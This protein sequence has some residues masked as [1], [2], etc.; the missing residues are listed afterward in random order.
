ARTSSPSA[1]PSIR[2]STFGL[3][4]TC[5]IPPLPPPCGTSGK[6]GTG[7]SGT[8]AVMPI[9]SPAVMSS[10]YSIISL[11]GEEIPKKD[12]KLLARSLAK[13]LTVSLASFHLSLIPPTRPST[14]PFPHSKAERA[15]FPKRLETQSQIPVNK[16]RTHSAPALNTSLIFSQKPERKSIIPP[17]ISDTFSF[18]ASHRPNNHPVT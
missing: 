2:I 6:S 10:P 3:K 11:D 15:R 14:T 8:S 7:I 18:V 5:P 9:C 1:F 17:H 13:F 16:S 4:V 12:L